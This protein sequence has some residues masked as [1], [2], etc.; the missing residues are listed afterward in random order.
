MNLVSRLTQAEALGDADKV[1]AS[2]PRGRSF[3]RPISLFTQAKVF[4][5]VNRV[6][7]SPLRGGGLQA[8]SRFSPRL[9]P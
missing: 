9:R 4:C 1:I 6:T 3:A 2:P 7:A 5:N 8:Q